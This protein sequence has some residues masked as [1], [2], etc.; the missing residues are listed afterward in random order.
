MPLYQGRGCSKAL[1]WEPSFRLQWDLEQGLSSSGMRGTSATSWD[2]SP[3]SDYAFERLKASEYSWCKELFAGVRVCDTWADKVDFVCWVWFK[4]FFLK[5]RF[6]Y[7]FLVILYHLFICSCLPIS[8]IPSPS[9]PCQIKYSS[10]LTT[11]TTEE[12]FSVLFPW[13]SGKRKRRIF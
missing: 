4:K 11:W 10:C 2:P 6:F 8:P 9:W 12:F 5:L 3:E 7:S 1:A 13:Y